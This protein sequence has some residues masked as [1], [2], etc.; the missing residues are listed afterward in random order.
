MQHALGRRFNRARY[1][2]EAVVAA[3]TVR[4][5]RATDLDPVR[6]DLAGAVDEAFQPAHVS[7]WL[8]G[9]RPDATV[10]APARRRP[11]WPGKRVRAGCGRPGAVTPR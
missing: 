3:F 4:L 8:P 9:A 2:A 1:D 7:V 5:R 6:G 10:P 11:A